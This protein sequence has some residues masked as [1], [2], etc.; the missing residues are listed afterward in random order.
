MG[1]VEVIR[2]RLLGKVSDRFVV[3]LEKLRSGGRFGCD[4]R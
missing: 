4:G 2:V 3:I 1:V